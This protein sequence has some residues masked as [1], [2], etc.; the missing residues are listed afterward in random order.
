[1]GLLCVTDLQSED[2]NQEILSFD[3]FLP[4]IPDFR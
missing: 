3:Q 4:Q 1:M 2:H